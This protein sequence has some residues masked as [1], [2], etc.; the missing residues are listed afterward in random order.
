MLLELNS[1]FFT[2][3]AVIMGHVEPARASKKVRHHKRMSFPADYQLYLLYFVRFDDLC[4]LQL[5]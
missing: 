1:I 5:I 2:L 3:V 4:G